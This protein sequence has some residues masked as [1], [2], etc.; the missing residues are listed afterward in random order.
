MVSKSS[1]TGGLNSM[2]TALFGITL[3]ETSSEDSSKLGMHDDAFRELKEAATALPA[4]SDSIQIKYYIGSTVRDIS[5]A[6]LT[7]LLVTQ[8]KKILI[9]RASWYKT[10]CFAI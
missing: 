6:V 1:V 4:T 5:C 3:L 8:S 7:L 10:A 2:L 9:K